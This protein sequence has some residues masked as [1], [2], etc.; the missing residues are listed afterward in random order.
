MVENGN[1]SELTDKQQ[2]AIIALLSEPT[3]SAAAQASKIGQT[4]LHRWLN[5]PSFAAAL[6]T[7][8]GQAFE[9]A[10]AALQGVSGKA[11]ETLLA[12]MQDHQAQ[13]SARVSA[14][15]TILDIAIK[16][17]E[18]FDLADRLK[19]IEEALKAKGAMTQ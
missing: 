9:T 3:I 12:I 4:T 14:A 17:R 19:A 6:K 2:K 16:A 18:Q 5:D 11:V 13:A 15:K 8:R 7:A 1:T 10:L